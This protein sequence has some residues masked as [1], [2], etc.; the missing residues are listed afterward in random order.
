MFVNEREIAVEWGH[1]DPAGIVFYPNYLAWFDDCTTAL[2]NAAGLP[3]HIL[4]KAHEVVGVPL[5]DLKVRFLAASTYNDKLRARS[6]VLEFK[7][8]SFQ[9][10]H[11]FF[12]GHALAVEG[13]ET[14]VWTGHD[15]QNPERLKS[16]PIPAEVIERLSVSNSS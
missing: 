15:P 2:F 5:V 12:K 11:Q 9:I 16:R 6:T 8:T 13:V 4:F 1:C 10:Q 3:T 7:R 14:R